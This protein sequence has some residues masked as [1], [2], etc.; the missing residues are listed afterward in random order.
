MSPEN[1]KGTHGNT[2][3]EFTFD[4]LHLGCS[5]YVICEK[6][7]ATLAT[8]IAMVKRCLSG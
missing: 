7:F 5:K 3:I 1:A 2:H 6:F 8:L 4:Q